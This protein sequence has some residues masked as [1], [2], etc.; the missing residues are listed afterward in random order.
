MTL[1]ARHSG[2]AARAARTAASRSDGRRHR[3]ARQ[4]LAG[5]GV[6]DVELLGAGGRGPLAS[7]VVVE[8]TGGGGG[9]S[10]HGESVARANGSLGLRRP[11][12]SSGQ[13]WRPHAP[14]PPST[15][16]MTSRA[17]WRASRLA[18]TAARWPEAQMTA[19][20]ASGSMPSGERVDVVVGRV[21]GARDVPALPLAAL[22][23]V[24]H[25]QRRAVL[26]ALVQ[27]GHRHARDARDRAAGPRASSSS[28]RRG[29]RRRWSTPTEA[30]S[31]IARA[32]VLV[33]AADEDHGLV[34]VGEPRQPRAEAGAQHGD[35]DRA[36]D[37]RVVELQLGADVD[38]QRAV[39]LVL[40][41]LARR[42]RVDLRRPRRPAARVLMATMARKFGG[43]GPSPA[44]ARSTN[45]LLVDDAAA[46]PGGRA[47]SRS[48]RRPSGRCRA[49]RT[50]SRR[51]ARAT[52]R[53]CRAA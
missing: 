12:S 9:G 36:G 40:L 17:P 28:R 45:S 11:P 35:A 18:P 20:G 44:I 41:D 16:W 37:V 10:A 31:P 6:G 22:A 51:G 5:G 53:T 19:T 14:T 48:S 50:A 15:T 1:T 38:D 26:P 24:E 7:H 47:R 13:P 25:L 8:Q 4:H 23:H 43:C 2:S 32:G 46:A 30:A 21:D 42:E 33:V 27:L 29:S 52:P 39:A 34:V 49:R 3:H